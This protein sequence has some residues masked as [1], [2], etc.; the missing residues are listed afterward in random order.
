MTQST[1]FDAVRA[2][3]IALLRGAVLRAE[4]VTA[5][6]DGSVIDWR[7]IK[8][9][10]TIQTDG[11]A[12]ETAYLFVTLVGEEA[13]M[14]AAQRDRDVPPAPVFVPPE[15]YVAAYMPNQDGARR[16]SFDAGP[17]RVIVEPHEDDAAQATFTQALAKLANWSI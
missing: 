17:F 7:S 4:D 16:R 14:A 10:E 5:G 13:A 3:S 2:C 6:L 8:S 12:F 11:D 1:T 9:G 15:V